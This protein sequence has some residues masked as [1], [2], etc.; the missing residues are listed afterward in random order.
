M[1]ACQNC[2]LYCDGLV[3]PEPDDDEEDENQKGK[4]K[5]TNSGTTEGNDDE[6]DE[7]EQER[8]QHEA[9]LRRLQRR[10]LNDVRYFKS[11]DLNK[12]DYGSYT[13]RLEKCDKITTFMK[14]PANKHR[15]VFVHLFCS[16]ISHR[17]FQDDI[18]I[19][20]WTN[21]EDSKR[22]EEIEK[23]AKAKLG[24]DDKEEDPKNSGNKP[25]S[26][27]ND[28]NVAPMAPHIAD[29]DTYSEAWSRK[30]DMYQR[31][32]WGAENCVI[33]TW[34]HEPEEPRF[35]GC[36]IFTPGRSLMD[37]LNF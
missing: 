7:D 4:E 8:K 37:A 24:Q 9:Q 20:Q 12:T 19:K 21:F 28:P 30:W 6:V 35:G 22:Y 10:H 29:N 15:I 32:Y 14:D 11:S 33:V 2:L 27:T 17:I 36:L 34:R 26:N 18:C 5:D 31:S 23:Q 13:Y 25:E 16:N 3:P 1:Y